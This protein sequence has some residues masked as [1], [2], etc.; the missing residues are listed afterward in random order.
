MTNDAGIYF[1]DAHIS[2]VLQKADQF[3]SAEQLNEALMHEVDLFRGVKP[4]PDDIA[5][6]TCKYIV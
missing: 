1:E 2:A 4:Y 3:I 5:M 6:L